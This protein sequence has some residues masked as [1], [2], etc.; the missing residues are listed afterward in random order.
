[1]SDSTFIVQSVV[2]SVFLIPWSVLASNQREPSG[3]FQSS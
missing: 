2:F 3:R 1:M